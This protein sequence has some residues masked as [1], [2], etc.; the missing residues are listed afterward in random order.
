MDITT[1]LFVYSGHKGPHDD[2]GQVDDNSLHNG[3]NEYFSLA[4]LNEKL[5]TWK[6]D[7]PQFNKVIALLL[8]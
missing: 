8:P 6:R 5:N 3:P 7:K 4:R 2:S 1:L